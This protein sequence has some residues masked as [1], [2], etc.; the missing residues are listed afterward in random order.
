METCT[1]CKRRREWGYSLNWGV[2][3]DCIGE[4]GKIKPVFTLAEIP[5][6]RLEGWNAPERYRQYRLKVLGQ[7]MGVLAYKSRPKNAG[8]PAWQVTYPDERM[9]GITAGFFGTKPQC[10]THFKEVMQRRI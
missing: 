9:P 5:N 2:C 6:E 1:N 3:R 10:L 7:V 8:G 4:D